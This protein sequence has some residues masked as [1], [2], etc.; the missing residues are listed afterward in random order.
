MDIFEISKQERQ[1][2]SFTTDHYYFNSIGL[3]A[4]TTGILYEYFNELDGN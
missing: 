3:G 2:H 4:F 1:T